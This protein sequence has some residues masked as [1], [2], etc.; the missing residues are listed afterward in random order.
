MDPDLLLNIAALMVSP[1]KQFRP[2]PCTLTDRTQQANHSAKTLKASS[3][4]IMTPHHGFGPH[5]RSIAAIDATIE[6]L[7]HC[8]W[9]DM[10]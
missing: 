3:L 9:V 4:A 2:G 8:S 10:T 1:L 5:C 6:T 7:Y